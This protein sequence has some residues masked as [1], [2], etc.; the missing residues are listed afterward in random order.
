MSAQVLSL[1]QLGGCCSHLL[2]TLLVPGDNTVLP[3]HGDELGFLYMLLV[4][5]GALLSHFY[6]FRASRPD[7][8]ALIPLMGAWARSIDLSSM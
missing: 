5:S 8:L 7:F 2:G 1:P 3:L 4:A 6:S